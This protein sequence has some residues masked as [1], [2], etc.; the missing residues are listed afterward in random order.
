[1][2]AAR[3]TQS[4]IHSPSDRVRTCRVVPDDEEINMTHVHSQMLDH[5]A[6]CSTG[7]SKLPE[8]QHPITVQELQ[9][10]TQ[11]S[12]LRNLARSTR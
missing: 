7:S 11:N 9:A 10:L 4:G 12:T 6:W 3:L 2:D 1:M 5:H 8:A